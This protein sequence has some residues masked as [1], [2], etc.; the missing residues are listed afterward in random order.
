MHPP[1][2]SIIPAKMQDLRPSPSFTKT[3]ILRLIRFRKDNRNTSAC[4]EL[5]EMKKNATSVELK[6]FW[7]DKERS[8][9]TGI[10]QPAEW[11][12]LRT[13]RFRCRTREVRS[14]LQSEMVDWIGRSHDSWRGNQTSTTDFD[15]LAFHTF[16]RTSGWSGSSDD[17]HAEDERNSSACAGEIERKQDR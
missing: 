5:M 6:Y 13:S 7:S 16:S 4:P 2:T 11:S 14:L 3:S 9:H 10:L 15:N 12:W 1:Y 17:P 8:L